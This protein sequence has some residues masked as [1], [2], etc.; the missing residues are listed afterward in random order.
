MV[1]LGWHFLFWLEF[2]FAL[3]L[4]E[5]RGADIVIEEDG[6]S[7]LVIDEPRMYNVVEAPSYGT[8][9]LKLSTSSPHFALYAFTFGIYASGI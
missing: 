4:V 8:F 7:F 6:R 2:V 5:N 3:W 9:E 1:A